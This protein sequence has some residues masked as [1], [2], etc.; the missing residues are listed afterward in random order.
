VRRRA[1]LH[2]AE[3]RCSFCGKS[4]RE[5]QVIVCGPGVGICNECLDRANARSPGTQA[6][7]C[8]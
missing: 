7:L 1:R 2:D 3:P 5:V 4:R 6:E 8:T